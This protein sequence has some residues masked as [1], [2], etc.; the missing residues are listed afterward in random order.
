MDPVTKRA[1]DFLNNLIEIYNKDA[2]ADKSFISESTSKF[3]A[4]RLLL[5]TQEL[6]GVEKD[7]E[8]FKTTNKL[9]DIE[10][11]AKLFI[12]GSAE[13]NKKRVEME[14]QLNMVASMLDFIKKSSYS[15]LLP[16]N[17]IS[18]KGDESKLDEFL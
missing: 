15:D 11:E 14:I 7:V 13:Y 6:D 10:T 5:I 8:S 16:T 17:M 9:T 12:E 2:A 4:N 3:I 18:S 1:E